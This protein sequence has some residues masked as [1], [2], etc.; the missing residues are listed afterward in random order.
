MTS[1]Q[2]KVSM[3]GRGTDNSKKEKK[4][5]NYSYPTDDRFKALNPKELKQLYKNQDWYSIIVPETE[6][7]R[8]ELYQP[9]TFD[10]NYLMSPFSKN[11]KP[12]FEKM[13]MQTLN[14]MPVV[15]WGI[16][17]EECISLVKSFTP[18]EKSVAYAWKDISDKSDL[19]IIYDPLG[20]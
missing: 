18:I 14:R 15:Y 3:L 1:A 17:G 5:T 13:T 11:V 6:W 10:R 19:L 7:N 4:V 20:S 16:E 12:K 9:S 8:K 2:L